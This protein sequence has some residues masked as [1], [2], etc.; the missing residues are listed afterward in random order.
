MQLDRILFPIKSLG[1][2]S[3]IA[4]WTIGCTKHCHKCISPE[5]WTR[6]ENKTMGIESIKRIISKI[7]YNYRVDGFTITGGDPLEQFSDLL[8]LLEWLH[9][10]SKDILVY[11]GYVYENFLKNISMTE[12]E[13]FEKTVGVLIDGPYTDDLNTEN[14]TL[15]GSSNQRIIFFNGLLRRQY[16][17]YLSEKRKIQNIYC[18]D[19]LISVGIHNKVDKKD[20]I[21]E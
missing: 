4:I 3:R 18:G 12:K 6:N 9:N 20:E 11:T 2:G 17:N 21:H 7:C 19:R 15:R 13:R 14:C 5:L 1:P 16:K 10:Y 8:P